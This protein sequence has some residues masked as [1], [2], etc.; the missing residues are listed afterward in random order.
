MA[1]ELTQ[2]QRRAV[3]DRGGTLLVSA[4]A[5]SG[6]TRVLVERL[7][8]HV[9]REGKDIDRFLVI[10]FTNAAAAELR[11]RVAQA[12]AE[13]L[14]QRPQDGHLRRQ[15][16]LVY[17]AKICTIDAFCIEFLRECGHLADV[18]PDF[19][20]CDEAE[21]ASLL[22]AALDEVLERRYDSIDH[23]PG[24]LELAETLAGDRDDQ[25]LADVVLDV[26]RRVQSHP[27]PIGWLRARQGDFDLP[28]DAKPEDTVW[29]RLLLSD[30]E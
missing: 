16:N 4:A 30:G 17:Q 9:V 25:T 6:K 7:M 14:A 26:H 15:T 5:G 28:A 29:G 10:T 19:R 1:F 13:R 23:D 3:E 18:D 12:L 27:D 21:S 11:S 8:D 22:T 24:F 2:E 20:I